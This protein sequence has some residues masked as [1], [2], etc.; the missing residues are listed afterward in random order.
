MVSSK[1]L[2]FIEVP[3]DREEKYGAVKVKEIHDNIYSSKEF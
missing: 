1:T 2:M 3:I